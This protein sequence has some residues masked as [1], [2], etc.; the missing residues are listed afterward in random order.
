MS[1]E[2]LIAVIDDDESFRT[3]LV[4]L[5]SSSGYRACGF[6]SAEAFIASDGIDSYSCIVSDI[7]MPGMSGIDLNSLLIARD[8]RVPVI[9]I[10]A[11]MEAGLEGKALSAGAVCLLHKPFK[12]DA[13]IGIIEANRKL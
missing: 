1:Q 11:R 6:R 8:C 5:L 7:H 4:D 10:T 9:M 13:L 3:A 12:A 2:P